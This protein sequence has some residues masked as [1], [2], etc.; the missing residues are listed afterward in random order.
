MNLFRTTSLKYEEEQEFISVAERYPLHNAAVF[1][2]SVEVEF[3]LNSNRNCANQEDDKGRIP[4]HYS[5]Q[6]HSTYISQLLIKYGANVD[7]V[8]YTEATPAHFAAKE[9]Q[10]ENSCLLLT[11][12]ADFCVR[13]KIGKTAFDVAAEEGHIELIKFLIQQNCHQILLSQMKYS[14]IK[15]I[16]TPLHLAA[17]NGHV[18]IVYLLFNAGF[19]LNYK[20]SQGTALHEGVKHGRLQVV[21]LLLYLGINDKAV[22]SYNLTAE[23]YGIQ[24]ISHNPVTAPAILE[25]LEGGAHLV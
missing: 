10:I 13:D 8:D 24:V 2:N 14:E 1:G 22:D 20:T 18:E 7:S 5:V 21:R 3:L 12:G 9:G 16:N 17:R 6:H 25:L 4:L 23:D 19:P 11:F 15:Q